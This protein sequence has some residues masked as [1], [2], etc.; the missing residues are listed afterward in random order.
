MIQPPLGDKLFTLDHGKDRYKYKFKLAPRKIDPV[1][2]YIMY[3]IKE[4]NDGNI[5]IANMNFRVVPTTNAPP[6]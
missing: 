2:R 5:R 1:I 6:F 4:M 3:A